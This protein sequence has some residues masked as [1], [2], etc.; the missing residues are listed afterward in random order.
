MKI[1]CISRTNVETRDRC[2]PSKRKGRDTTKKSI[3][4]ELRVQQL[5]WDKFCISL[6]ES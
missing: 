6:W 2:C 1:N 4:V 5:F 3:F